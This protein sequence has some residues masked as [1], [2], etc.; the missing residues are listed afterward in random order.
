[1]RHVIVGTAG[2]IDHGK[3]ALVKA[4]TGIDPDRLKEEKVRGITIDLGFAHLELDGIQLGFV[5][6]PGHEKFVK[7]ML[8][9]VGGIDFVMMVVAADESVMPQTQEH[10]D[11][12]RLLGIKAG[13]VAITKIDVVD[14]EFVELV[15]EE[16]R[17][18]FRESFLENAPIIPVSSKTGEGI[19]R[20]KEALRDLATTVAERPANRLFRLPVDR[21]FS[22]RGFGT[23]VTGTLITGNL[24]KESEVELIP[25][26][27]VARVRGI[28]VHGKP[29][30]SAVAGQRTAVNLQG[31]DLSQVRRGMVLT[32]PRVFRATQIVDARLTLLPAAHALKNMIKVRFHQGTSEVLA[33]VALLGKDTLIP[34]ESAFAQ[35]RL[36]APVFCLH[37]DAFI[38]RQFSP[39]VTVGGGRVL[40]PHP[41][42][43]RTSD[44]AILDKLQDLEGN[45]YSKVIPAL[46]A[47]RPEPAISLKEL[48]SYLD[49]P[50]SELLPISSALSAD[51]KVVPVPGPSPILVAGAV[52]E[53]LEKDTVRQL[54]RFHREFPLLKGM[55]REELRRRVYDR[56]PPE[57][58]R[59]CLE[60]LATKQ[61]V[62]LQEDVISA[63][64]REV[65]LSAEELE[66]RKKIEE[67]FHH[68]GYQP[69][70]FQDLQTSLYE[71][72]DRL[73]KVYHWML[74]ER[75]LI[76]ITEDLAY[77]RD[78]LEGIRARIRE[79]HPRGSR[80]GVAAF[81]ELFDLT[82]KHA[83][84]LLEYL[85]RERF[86]RREGNDRVL[87]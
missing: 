24:R 81:K 25:G 69:P 36:D 64:G 5:D 3:S 33:R 67:V 54:A 82:R 29:T 12:C 6:V 55:S 53:T 73:R 26:N 76:R 16:I 80:F 50:E 42:K 60:D 47:D 79:R 1:M 17:E 87:L 20:L 9:G 38:I 78:T 14:A 15:R 70:S 11:I 23:V 43:H 41:R 39:T 49:L 18:T 44:T 30:E 51:R 45:D 48:N 2:H 22:I 58:F 68:S 8:A 27:L 56:L 84:P 28:Q 63:F 75:I 35:L 59:Y 32:V 66:L 4:L 34:G 19:D 46:I 74:K 83:I 71:D 31:V 13:V 86:T 21:G 52:I 77:H 65:Q 61:Q 37:G 40:N 85:D 72:P 62:S 7:N 10:F 57:V